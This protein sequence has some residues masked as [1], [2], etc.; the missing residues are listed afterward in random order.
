MQIAKLKIEN[1]RGIKSFNASFYDKKLVCLI[2][3]GDSCKSTILDAI[4]YVLSPTWNIQINDNDFY[5]GDTNESILISATITVPDDF[6]LESKY[7]TYLRSFNPENYEINN[8]MPEGC[9]RVLTINLEI[10]D[11]LEPKWY[12]YKPTE[13]EI[14]IPIGHKDREK[15]NCFVVSNYLDKHFTWGTGTPLNSLAKGDADIKDFR[16]KYLSPLREALEKINTSTNFNA[17]ND[18]FNEKVKTPLISIDNTITKMELRD[19]TYNI[20]KFSLHDGN[21][22]YRLKGNGSR[23]LLSIAIQLA[24][25]DKNGCITLVDEIEQGLEPDRTKQLIATLKESTNKSSQIFITTHSKNVIEELGAENLYI[26]RTNKG[27]VSAKSLDSSF[28]SLVRSCPEAFFAK[29][30]IV[31][32]G[33]TE[34]GFCRAID[35]YLYKKYNQRMAYNGCV[36][37]LGGGSD[38]AKRASLFNKLDYNVLVFCDSDRECNPSKEILR[39][40]GIEVCDCESG[41]CIEQQVFKDIPYE[42]ILEILKYLSEEKNETVD[43]LLNEIKQK[44]N[45]TDNSWKLLDNDIDREYLINASLKKDKKSGELKHHWFKEVGRGEGLCSIILINLDKI[46]E[47]KKIKIII[48]KILNWSKG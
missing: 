4:S 12:V 5:N 6:I 8:D 22:P 2:G 43:M 45:I 39:A 7:G 17:L 3:R 19:I 44:N 47:S 46:S 15:L 37:V 11:E 10:N 48:K 25:K 42:A 18:I 20:N 35:T 14:K 26:I 30:I 40:G 24:T 34:I 31:C 13:D 33:K 23:R 36:Y 41:N 16:T 1:F 27:E 38:F 21:V 32:E 29:K 28:D 9:I